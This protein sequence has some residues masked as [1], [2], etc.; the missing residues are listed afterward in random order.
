M[1][2]MADGRQGEGRG[3]PADF[4]AGCTVNVGELRGTRGRRDRC[5][6]VEVKAY[7]DVAASTTDSFGATHGFV[8]QR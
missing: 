4:N 6:G 1:V 3:V 2:V 5:A 8:W 7:S